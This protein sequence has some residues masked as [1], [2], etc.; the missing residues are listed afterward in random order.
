[1]KYDVNLCRPKVQFLNVFLINGILIT[2]FSLYF[3]SMVWTSYLSPS[4]K[5]TDGVFE[6][7]V[8]T[9]TFGSTRGRF[10][11]GWRKLRKDGLLE[12]TN[13]VARI[14]CRPVS[15]YGRSVSETSNYKLSWT[16]VP[17]RWRRCGFPEHWC[18]PV[19]TALC[20][21]RRAFL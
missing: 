6:I 17:W 13:F 21:G 15:H 18:L 12:D 16:A 11:G 5:S 3:Y 4:G 20:A 14:T 1:M 19:E 2:V 10:A 7:R 8:L 9:R